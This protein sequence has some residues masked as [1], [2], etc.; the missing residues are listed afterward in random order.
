MNNPD[1]SWLKTRDLLREHL[2]VPPLENPDFINSRVMDEICRPVAPRPTP[3]LSLR[4]LFWA[5]ATALLTAGL[6]T[7]VLM[8]REFGLRDESEFISQVVNARAETPHLSVSQFRAP[9]DRGVVLWIEGAE[10]IPAGEPVR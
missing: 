2:T 3:R 4:W 5:G 7:A 1:E 10:F 9:D 8:P 6:L